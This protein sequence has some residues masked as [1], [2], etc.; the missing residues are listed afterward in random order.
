MK[1]NKEVMNRKNRVLCK[2][3]KPVKFVFDLS[4]FKPILLGGESNAF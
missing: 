3:N 1:E 4:F 2:V